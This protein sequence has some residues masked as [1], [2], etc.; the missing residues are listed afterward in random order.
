MPMISPPRADAVVR[1][2]KIKV[3]EEWSAVRFAQPVPRAEAFRRLRQML[4]A[5]Q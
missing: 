5:M 3:D 2:I 4:E 1:E